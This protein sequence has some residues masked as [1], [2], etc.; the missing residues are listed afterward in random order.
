M[1]CQES[2]HLQGGEYVKLGDLVIISQSAHIYD[3]CWEA[4]DSTFTK[5]YLNAKHQ[6]EADPAGSF[7]IAIDPGLDLIEVQ[8][9]SPSPGDEPLQ[10]FT[11]KTPRYLMEQ[12]LKHCPALENS[13]CFYLGAEIQKAYQCLQNNSP[14]SQD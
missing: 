3:D 6:F 14:Y 9:I 12:I 8:H 11:G 1:K 5:Y 10:H 2:P 4:A 7:T 13:H